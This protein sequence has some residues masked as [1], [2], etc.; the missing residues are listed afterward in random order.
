M[1]LLKNYVCVRNIVSSAHAHTCASVSRHRSLARQVTKIT[2][3]C[4]YMSTYYMDTGAKHAFKSWA[5][6]L[7]VLWPV[8]L[9]FSVNGCSLVLLPTSTWTS[10]QDSA[11]WHFTSLPAHCRPWSVPDLDSVYNLEVQCSYFTGSMLVTWLYL[12]LNPLHSHCITSC[13]PEHPILALYKFLYLVTCALLLTLQ[14]LFY[15]LVVL[16]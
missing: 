16:M 15:L 7:N 3:Q 8:E 9:L 10:D 5:L 1:Y 6:P 13:T 14:A 4:R 2:S 12:Y 11:W